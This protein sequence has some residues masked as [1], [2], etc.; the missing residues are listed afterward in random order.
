MQTILIYTNSNRVQRNVVVDYLERIGLNIRLSP[1][2]VSAQVL[3]IDEQY[4]YDCPPDTMPSFST[5]LREAS[6]LKEYLEGF[7]AIVIITENEVL[8]K[9]ASEID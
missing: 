2:P 3:A 9:V 6:F 1:S 4:F 7:E 5:I 8:G